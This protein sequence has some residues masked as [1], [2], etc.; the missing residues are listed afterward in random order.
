MTE[1]SVI[2]YDGSSTRPS[3]W[4]GVHPSELSDA[5]DFTSAGWWYCT[6]FTGDSG[7]WISTGLNN[8][9]LELRFS[10]S[11]ENTLN[12]PTTSGDY[13]GII[14]VIKIG[15]S[16]GEARRF[17]TGGSGFFA[18][19]SDFLITDIGLGASMFKRGAIGFI[20]IWER[21]GTNINPC[22]HP[23]TIIDSI[24]QPIEQFDKNPHSLFNRNLTLGTT[25]KFICIKKNS[26]TKTTPTQ[27]LY[28]TS[29]H[30][31]LHQNEEVIVDKLINDDTIC[32]VKIDK[33][34]MTYTLELKNN[35]RGPIKMH[36][37]DVFQWGDQ[38]FKNFCKKWNCRYI[39]DYGLVVNKSI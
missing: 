11:S 21:D 2:Y 23:N 22:I 4:E 20:R 7:T 16:V 12:I 6:D 19:Y 29:G 33:P 24:A 38:D 34:V 36:G 15:S 3:Q 35:N 8:T 32:K 30:P 5:G 37:V 18:S 26:L 1:Y 27:D 14:G 28:L 13:I 10:G 25:D 17:Q 9:D 39:K 31:I